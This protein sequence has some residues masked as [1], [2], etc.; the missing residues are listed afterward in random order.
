MVKGIFVALW[1]EIQLLSHQ[2]NQKSSQ[3]KKKK[4]KVLS[5]CWPFSSQPTFL[6]CFKGSQKKAIMSSQ[7]RT[8]TKTLQKRAS[9]ETGSFIINKKDVIGLPIPNVFRLQLLFLRM[10]RW[11]AIIRQ[12]RNGEHLFGQCCLYEILCQTQGRYLTRNFFEVFIR[13]AEWSF[14]EM[15]ILEYFQKFRTC[16]KF[17]NVSFTLDRIQRYRKNFLALKSSEYLPKNLWRHFRF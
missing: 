17:I 15:G 2:V 1:F 6:M 5:S 11:F 13:K 4:R 8:S 7:Q 16:L 3:K 9:R 12:P 10:K 14:L